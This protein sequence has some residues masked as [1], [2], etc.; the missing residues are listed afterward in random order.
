MTVSD[1]SVGELLDSVASRALTPSGGAVGALCGASGAALCEMTCLHTLANADDN[2]E[3]ESV[4]LAVVRDD[5]ADRR[6]QLVALADDDVAAVEKLQA[7]L[8]SAESTNENDV[9][10]AAERATDVPLRTGGASLAVLELATAVT[11]AGTARA[12]PDAGTGASLAH[13]SVRATVWTARSNLGLL[14]DAA[15]VADFE[16]RIAALESASESAIGTVTDNVRATW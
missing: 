8:E 9:Q 7:T 16:D 5:L 14:E 15:V 12:V 10:D 11:E 4:D 2:A 6:E 13:A 3:H 1:L